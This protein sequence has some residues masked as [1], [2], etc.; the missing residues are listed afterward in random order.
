MP[1]RRLWNYYFILFF[2]KNKHLITF[3][4][5]Y[6]TKY[7]RIYI[8]RCRHAGI[9][10]KMANN[11]L[12]D[13]SNDFVMSLVTTHSWWYRIRNLIMS[14]N[15]NYGN[16]VCTLNPLDVCSSPTLSSS[17]LFTTV[18]RMENSA[19]T[20]ERHRTRIRRVKFNLA[21]ILSQ[22]MTDTK[23]IRI[24]NTHIQHFSSYCF[25]Q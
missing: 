13:A 20:K 2:F 9:I 22:Q 6:I 21:I 25:I 5:M 7:V 16:H 18:I 10:L 14:T 24:Q 1:F 11:L 3:M 23:K 12:T 19:Y 4:Y 17:S 15:L 8:T